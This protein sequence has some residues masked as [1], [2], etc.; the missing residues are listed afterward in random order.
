MQNKTSKIKTEHS[1]CKGYDDISN[2]TTCKTIVL[3]Q[4]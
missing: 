1:R 2:I 4:L 3:K